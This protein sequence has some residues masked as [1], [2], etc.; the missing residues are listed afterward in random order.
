MV[1]RTGTEY[2]AGLRGDGREVRLGAERV[3]DV[4]EHPALRGSVRGMAGFFDWQHRH[5]ED[6]IITDPGSNQPAGISHLIPRSP[7]MAFG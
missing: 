2:R 1:A 4:T 5:R 7:A 6:C 3:G